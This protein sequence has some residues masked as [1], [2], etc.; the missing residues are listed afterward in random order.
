MTDFWS[1]TGATLAAIALLI[2]VVY[3]LIGRIKKR[4]DQAIG[5][6]IFASYLV[7]VCESR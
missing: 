1:I 4:L 5:I 2:G 6:V 7:L 3:F